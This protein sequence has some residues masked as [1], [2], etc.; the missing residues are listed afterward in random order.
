MKR[1]LRILIGALL[2]LFGG[3]IFF[4]SG[5]LVIGGVWPWLLVVVLGGALAFAGYRIIAGD[6]L[7]DILEDLLFTIIRTN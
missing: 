2:I 3:V 7:K 5:R 6:K 1:I 4:V